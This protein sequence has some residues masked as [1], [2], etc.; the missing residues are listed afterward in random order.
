MIFDERVLE[1]GRIR[2]LVANL[3]VCDLGR[4]R[5]AEAQPRTDRE[6]LERDRELVR[7]MMSLLEGRREPPIH[8]LRDVIEYLLKDRQFPRAFCFCLISLGVSL[9]RLPRHQTPARRVADLREGVERLALARLDLAGLHQWIDQAQ[10]A[11]AELHGEIHS[12][13]FAPAMTQ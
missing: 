7:E 2:D 1:F 4:R 10:I 13:W 5:M 12:T 6:D 8:E 9:E 3:C 11:V